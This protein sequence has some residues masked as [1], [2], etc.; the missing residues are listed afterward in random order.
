MSHVSSLQHRC[1]NI[2]HRAATGERRAQMAL[3]IIRATMEEAITED[4]A[5]AISAVWKRDGVGA[6]HT[7]FQSFMCQA[8]EGEVVIGRG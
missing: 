3:E 2:C 4:Q 8:I 1:L 7:L 5:R 6:A